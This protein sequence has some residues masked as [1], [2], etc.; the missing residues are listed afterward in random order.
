MRAASHERRSPLCRVLAPSRLAVDSMDE[1]DRKIGLNEALFRQINERGEELNE[2]F[3]TVTDRMQLVC[4][5][6]DRGCIEQINVSRAEYEEIRRDPSQ[7]LIVPGHDA[8]GVEQTVKQDDGY[9]VVR[10]TDRDSI[11]LA[12]QT[13]PRS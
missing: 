1:R 8:A 13:D 12:E 10:K 2:A 6:G 3:A 11:A 4:E 5:C 7:F 9:A